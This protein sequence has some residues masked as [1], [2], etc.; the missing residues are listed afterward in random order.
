MELPAIPP[1]IRPRQLAHDI[2]GNLRSLDVPAFFL[3]ASIVLNV[4][5]LTLVS[6]LW[7]GY[8]HGGQR[9]FYVLNIAQTWRGHANEIP[10]SF[11][12]L[13]R[14]INP[15]N[16]HRVSS[17]A[18]RKWSDVMFRRYC[19]P[20]DNI[21]LQNPL[22]IALNRDITF[23]F[24]EDKAAAQFPITGYLPY[25]AGA[26]AG[27]TLG[28]PPAIVL[29]LAVLCNAALVITMGYYTL[30]LLPILRWPICYLFLIPSVIMNRIFVMPDALNIDLCF[31]AF[32]LTLNLMKA[33]ML[34]STG[35][36]ISQLILA[37][38]IGVT[39][40]AYA[41]V[42]GIFLFIPESCYGGRGRKKA[43]LALIVFTTA[44]AVG[45]WGLYVMS[46]FY[47]N[48]DENTKALFILQNPLSYLG[49]ALKDM[50]NLTSQVNNLL[51][52]RYCW[53]TSDASLVILM[54]PLVLSSLFARYMESSPL[55]VTRFER[56]ACIAFYLCGYLLV[57]TVKFLHTDMEILPQEG[58]YVLTESWV[59]GRYIIPFLPFLLV[60]M[61][62]LIPVK[63]QFTKFGQM[64]VIFLLSCIVYLHYGHIISPYNSNLCKAAN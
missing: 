34:L 21:P 55:V 1:S 4:L 48:G 56:L 23:P 60:A 64:I 47:E 3:I 7:P 5:Y 37:M 10:N 20:H 14:Q 15:E 58:G 11:L 31:F 25:A 52:W 28:L 29:Y 50:L 35:Q 2:I 6:P 24:T 12:L 41:P 54:L 51:T 38:L 44:A 27:I 8:P 9:F 40:M 59:Q 17:I 39:K 61:H 32:A 30:C 26:W 18:C 63:P 46:H 62:G 42:T 53:I 19:L 45:G 13:E 49:I 33:P 16:A 43:F 57:F 22:S 36:K